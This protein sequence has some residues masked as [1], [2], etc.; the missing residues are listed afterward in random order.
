MLAGRDLMKDLKGKEKFVLT[1]KLLA[2][3]TGKKMGKSEGNMVA[4]SDQPD[5]MFGKVM[6]WSDDM[7]LKGFELCTR[8]STGEIK[9]IKNNLRKGANPRDMKLRLASE[10]VKNFLGKKQAVQAQDYFVSTFSKKEIPGEMPEIKPSVYDVITVLVEGKI[11][12]SK[13]EARQLI[14]QGGIRV[15]ETKISFSEGALGPVVLIKVKAGD[16]IQKGSR[17]FIKVK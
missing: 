13:S 2:D 4:L 5:D 6:S 16:I 10:I 3:S 17:F 1:M 11:C 14:K 9:E 15:N 8:V 12:K 7:I